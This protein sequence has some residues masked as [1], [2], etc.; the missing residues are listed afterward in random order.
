MRRPAH[1]VVGCHLPGRSLA[2]R[3]QRSGRGACAGPC[4]SWSRCHASAPEGS[5]AS[6]GEAPGSSGG[7]S[8]PHGAWATRP[9]DVCEASSHAAAGF[10]AAG[11]SGDASSAGAC[12]GGSSRET[13][14][15]RPPEDVCHSGGFHP[16]GPSVAGVAVPPRTSGRAPA[17]PYGSSAGGGGGQ[18]PWPAGAAEGSSGRDTGVTG[19]DRVRADGGSVAGCRAGGAGTGRSSAGRPSTECADGGSSH[20]PARGFSSLVN[21]Y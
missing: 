10:G 4:G 7:G 18:P 19:A 5:P 13:A 11:S 1:E 3:R 21:S 15:W 8:V 6:C 9:Q 20:C 17:S 16:P 14:R 2:R 12:R